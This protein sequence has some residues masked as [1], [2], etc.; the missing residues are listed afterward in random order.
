M[1]RETLFSTLLMSII[2][3]SFCGFAAANIYSPIAHWKL[4][5]T[6]GVEAYDSA[7]DNYDASVRGGE[8]TS[9]KIGGALNLQTSD[10]YNYIS[11]PNSPSTSFTTEDFTVS[12]WIKPADLTNGG[13]VGKYD[14]W[15]EYNYAIWY[16]NETLYFEVGNSGQT[17]DDPE[18]FEIV[19]S[20]TAVDTAGQWYH[21]TATY[22]HSYIRLYVDGQEADS[23]SESRTLGQGP[24]SLF[25]GTVKYDGISYNT[26]NETNAPFSGL[27]DD[28]RIYDYALDSTEVYELYLIPEPASVMLFMAGMFFAAFKNKKHR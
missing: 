27:V 9:G 15:A 6:Y 23:E 5:E 22:D 14:N 7:G 4:D 17:I 11:V 20:S 10:Y 2:I 8:W 19:V 16:E 12:I 26:F 25:I 21:I 13:I 24:S 18:Q 28:I 3:F 1:K